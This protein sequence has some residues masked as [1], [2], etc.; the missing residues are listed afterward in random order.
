MTDK[1]GV[2]W[3]VVPAVLLNMLDDKNEKK[4]QAA[5]AAMLQMKKLDIATLQQAFDQA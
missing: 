2:S 3:Q 4:S 1:Y 5:M